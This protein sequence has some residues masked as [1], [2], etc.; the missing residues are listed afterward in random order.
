[1][2][3]QNKI[4]SW[5]LESKNPSVKY[6]TLTELMDYSESDHDVIETKKQIAHSK[7]VEN[8]FDKM[9]PDGYWLQ[10]NPRTKKVVGDGVEYGSF[11]TTH[12]V[13]S[14]LAELGLTRENPLI[15][16]VAER[17]LSLQADDGDWWLHMSCLI[18]Y[19]IHTFIKLGYKN[20]ERVKRATDYLL[21]KNLPDGGYL[22]SM[23]E[24]KYKTK[25]P[26]SCIRGSAKALLAFSFIPE[27]YDHPRVKLLID[28]F[29]N[30]NGIY[31]TKDLTSFANKD[32]YRFT[33]PITWG[34][35]SWEI[36]LALSKMGYGKDE[37][38]N[39]AW[40]FIESKK[41]ENG[42]YR[43]D[44]SP[45]QSPWKVGKKGEENKWLTFYILLAKKIASK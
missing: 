42:K 35:N 5:L 8:L 38:L 2:A 34:T 1:M 13:L 6:R 17:Y 10:K 36:L 43:L 25:M 19:N 29:L 26:K 24:K 23:H 20:D 4:L 33:Y 16:K 7:P 27:L 41:T 15:E 45:G 30:R 40:E 18:G 44:Y 22:C 3:H 12:F 28:Y 11:A 39:S 31:K 37:R 32:M 9:H 21:N 14:Y